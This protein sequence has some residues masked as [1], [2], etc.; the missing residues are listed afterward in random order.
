MK[1]FGFIYI[2]IILFGSYCPLFANSTD[3][4]RRDSCVVLTDIIIGG[5]KITKES[6]IKRELLF[7]K[8]DTVNWQVLESLMARSRENLL[9]T[10]LFNYVTI[11]K[12]DVSEFEKQVL[13]MVEERWYW[14]PYIIFEQ[15]D[16]NL[17][18]FFKDKD[19]SRIN[20]GLMLIKNNF[21]GRAETLK[22]KFRLG[23][24]QQFQIYYDIPYLFDNKRHGIGVQY[25]WYRQ[26]EIAYATDS[27]KPQYFKSNN[28]VIKNQDLY[29]FYTYRPHHDV[30]HIIS[31]CYARA[32]VADTVI[33]LNPSFFSSQASLAQY[34]SL[35]Y[36]FDWD[37]R[38]SKTYPLKGHNLTC[39]VGKIGLGIIDNEYDGAWY[40]KFNS[41]KYFEISNRWYAG[42]GG[43]AKYSPSKKQ[44]YYTEQALGYQDYLRG[45]EYFV[46]D[47]QR[48]VTSRAFAKFAIV[49][50]QV[51]T[52]DNWSWEKFN[53]VHYSLY[54]N[55]FV[56][57]GYVDDINTE[58][59]N[60]LANKTLVSAGVGLDLVTYY[61][62]VFRLE[63]TM[64]KQ[65]KS[66]LYIH[67]KKAF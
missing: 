53:K 22:I 16:R 48:F 32:R 50:T 3:T 63:A 15:A 19:W 9:N 24:K 10:S 5:N 11:S 26:K 51:S 12:I 58:W 37:C 7:A 1:K 45:F 41:Y 40:T 67:V 39:E 57:A 38:N 54:A 64:T 49:P 59:N 56:D 33:A 52:I 13:I 47:G 18:A 60:Y 46:I 66:G 25:S 27:C 4:I 28:S 65:G 43:A 2:V 35:S 31:T 17:S 8:N 34:F 61:D 23:Y 20:Y 42:V 30:R 21:R 36:T 44:P 62:L 14:W 29:L 55:I 6:I